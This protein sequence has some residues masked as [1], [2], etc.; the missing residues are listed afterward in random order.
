MTVVCLPA[1]PHRGGARS[2]PSAVSEYTVTKTR[3]G[4]SDASS[5]SGRM[6]ADLEVEVKI[7]CDDITR[8]T[9]SKLAVACVE[10]R[11]FEDNW[12]Y[13]IPDGNLR[14]GQYLRIRYT[15]DGDG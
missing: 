10:H 8:L 5:S 15:G 6:P 2:H 13:Q 3:K 9:D 12:I 7:R 14:K 4:P 1:V 11:H